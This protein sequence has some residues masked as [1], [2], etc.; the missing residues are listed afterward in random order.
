[1][2]RKIISLFTG[3]LFVL[4]ACSDRDLVTEREST[5]TQ[6]PYVTATPTLTPTPIQ[7]LIHEVSAEFEVWTYGGELNDSAFDVLLLEDGG[8]LIAGL[9]DSPGNSHRITTGTARL[10]RTDAEGNIV[11]QRDYGGELDAM[12]CSVIQVGENEFVALGEIAASYER[13]ETDFY[14]VKIDGDGNEIWSR[15][16]GGRGM[17]H[18]KVIIQSTDGG[19]VLT[20]SRADEYPS[21]NV[22]KGQYVIIRTDADGNE[23]WTR[24]YGSKVL[25]LTWGL[26]QTPDGGFVVA[27]WEARTIDD[28]DVFATKLDENGIMEWTHSWDLTPGDRDG[29]FG[30]VLTSDGF[31]V[32]AYLAA[33]N[34]NMIRTGAIKVDLNGNEI[35]N[36]SYGLDEAGNE[37][38]GITED[39]DGGYVLSGTTVRE[40]N[41]ATGRLLDN[42]LV[43]KIDSDGNLLWQYIVSNEDYGQV[44][45]G[46][47]VV[48]PNGDYAF[49]GALTRKG[50][51][52]SD[53]LLLR[54]PAQPGSK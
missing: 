5:P 27:G 45:I 8:L 42:G 29:G 46:A 21:G 44:T 50:E 54:I 25:Y 19:L 41:N 23:I 18:G 39:V 38:W 3:F 26:A 22:Y 52:N 20:G 33:M 12:F 1:M 40:R 14:L 15:T 49:V 11:W 30:M 28:R 10:I 34:S 13:D 37:F 35:W 32:I 24:L 47:S 4:A 43:V 6:T 7:T 17:D 53:M 36:K 51:S 2:L 16:Y 48:L 9:A 31:V